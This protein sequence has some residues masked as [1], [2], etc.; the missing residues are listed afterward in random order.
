MSA[1]ASHRRQVPLQDR[2]LGH[3][4]PVVVNLGHQRH[5]RN[6]AVSATTRVHDI[7]LRLAWMWRLVQAPAGYDRGLIMPSDLAHNERPMSDH[8]SMGRVDDVKPDLVE[9]EEEAGFDL[10]TDVAHPQ[11]SYGSESFD[12]VNDLGYGDVPD[13]A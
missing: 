10:R 2:L 4:A 5:D 8:D 7:D 6:G 12:I 13:D 11:A 3:R 9:E 1:L